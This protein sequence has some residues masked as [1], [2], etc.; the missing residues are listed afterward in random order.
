MSVNKQI[1]EKL[2]THA[3]LIASYNAAAVLRIPERALKNGNVY[4]ADINDDYD[5][6]L[7]LYHYRSDLIEDLRL[8]YSESEYLSICQI[9]GVIINANQGKIVCKSYPC[10]SNIPINTVPT[11][12]DFEI[13]DYIEN[14]QPHMQQ[15]FSMRKK[16]NRYIIGAVLRLFFVDGMPF[17]STHKKISFDRSKF[18]SDRSFKEMFFEAQDCF[19]A[20]FEMID[21]PNIVHT[22]I[23]S[24]ESLNVDSRQII[25]EDKIYYISSFKIENGVSFLDESIENQMV[26]RISELNENVEK[27]IHFPEILTPEEVNETLNP[28]GVR[29]PKS[30]ISN[31]NMELFDRMKIAD[32]AT[33]IRRY[34]QSGEKVAMRTEDGMINSLVPL[35]AFRRMTFRGG[36]IDLRNNLCETIGFYISGSLSQRKVFVDAGFPIETLREMAPKFLAGENIDFSEYP[37]VNCSIF[38]KIITNLFFSVPTHKIMEVFTVIEDYHV[39]MRNAFNYVMRRKDEIFSAIS[40]KEFPEKFPGISGKKT[41]RNYFVTRFL[42]CFNTY[43]NKP[44]NALSIIGMGPQSWWPRDLAQQFRHNEQKYKINGFL[45]IDAKNKQFM[46]INAIM[47]FVLNAEDIN[48]YSIL[49]FEKYVTSAEEAKKRR[50]MIQNE[51]ADEKF[52]EEVE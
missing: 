18:G 10:T 16:Y 13:G 48:H 4:I 14:P 2:E 43:Q 45:K 24:S 49:V 29:M 47:C 32:A 33:N 5:F 25:G 22:F 51:E 38:E 42:S 28:A 9:R 12:D 30:Y 17:I 41:I 52:R 40:K 39:G 20:E 35:S 44:G 34:F 15:L 7:V 3:E 11:D 21:R 6:V 50:E 31:S 23:I 8:D 46:T 1:R 36:K 26:A 19:K 27:K 37:V